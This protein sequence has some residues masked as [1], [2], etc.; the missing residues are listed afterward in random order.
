MSGITTAI[1]LIIAN[2]VAVVMETMPEYH[3]SYALHFRTFEVVS[4]A[5]FTIEYLARIYVVD[6][7]H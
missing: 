4:V 1:I 5:I 3:A 7:P 6:K 2:V